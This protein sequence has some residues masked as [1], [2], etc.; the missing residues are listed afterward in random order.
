M[1]MPLPVQ[2]LIVLSSLCH[3]RFAMAFTI[4]SHQ[5]SDAVGGLPVVAGLSSDGP[6]F[7]SV[8]EERIGCFTTPSSM[9]PT[10]VDTCRPALTALRGFPDYRRK[11]DFQRN[12]YPRRPLTPPFTYRVAGATCEICLE[13][14]N[15][16][17][18]E[19]FSWE[20]IRAN[21]QD[22][23]QHCQP[24]NEA[25]IGGFLVMGPQDLWILRVKGVDPI[26]GDFSE[27]EG[28]QTLWVD[29]DVAAGSEI[30]TFEVA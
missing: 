29:S 23:L 4:Q 9:K 25:G 19:K 1:G 14:L 20:E 17:V 24:P 28:N 26:A 11:Q 7:T 30:A 18:V 8:N 10:T 22:I 5:S 21:S 13:A 3:M 6:N 27:L 16:R 12:R 2:A 15:N